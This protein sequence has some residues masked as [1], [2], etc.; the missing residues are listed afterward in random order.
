MH[1]RYYPPDTRRIKRVRVADVP[2]EVRIRAASEVC[3]QEH[4]VWV[5]LQVRMLAEDPGDLC[6]WVAA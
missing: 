2:H 5:R 1:S 3:K 6:A 4:D